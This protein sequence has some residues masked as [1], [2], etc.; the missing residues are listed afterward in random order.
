MALQPPSPSKA[1]HSGFSIKVCPPK[2]NPCPGGVVPLVG[3]LNSSREARNTMPRQPTNC[4]CTARAA[5]RSDIRRIR[6]KLGLSQ[7]MAAGLT[8]GGHNA[9]S[10]HERGESAPLPAVVNLFRLLDRY[11]DL[12]KEP[13]RSRQ[14]HNRQTSQMEGRIA[15]GLRSICIQ[16]RH[17]PTPHFGDYRARRGSEEDTTRSSLAG[18]L[19]PSISTAGLYTDLYGKS[20]EG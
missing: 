12:L 13:P 6:K 9:F 19:E 14:P 16:N 15:P 7:A 5:Q 11:P 1:R 4:C 3:R 17:H 20:G 10:R 18:N 8:G 2:S